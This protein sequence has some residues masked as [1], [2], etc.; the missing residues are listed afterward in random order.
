LMHQ[1]RGWVGYSVKTGPRTARLA[2]T[3]KSTVTER[4]N[5]DRTN[6][7]CQNESTATECMNDVKTNQPR[8][9]ESTVTRHQAG[10][11]NDWGWHRHLAG[12]NTAFGGG[13]TEP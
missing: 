9:N 8:P 2:A 3:R 13:A 11:V 1:A 10:A 12:E 7:R 4:I 6:E 5:G